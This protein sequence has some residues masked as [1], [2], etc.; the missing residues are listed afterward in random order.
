MKMMNNIIE[1]KDYFNSLYSYY[2]ELL[3]E[4]QRVVFESYYFE[5]FSLKEISLELDVSRNA[6]WDILKTVEKN[7]ED[8]EKKLKLYEN[9]L[10]LRNLLHILENHVDEAGLEIINKIKEME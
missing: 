9:D 5:D 3:T 10:K 8:Y 4:K 6:I 1:K 7:L 2:Q